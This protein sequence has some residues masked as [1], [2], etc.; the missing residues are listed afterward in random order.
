[1][2]TF[3]REQDFQYFKYVVYF[4]ALISSL[5]GGASMMISSCF[6][7]VCDITNS[8]NLTHRLAILQTFAFTGSFIGYNLAALLMKYFKLTNQF[9]LGFSFLLFLHLCNIFISCIYIKLPKLEA[10]TEEKATIGNL[11]HKKHFLYN[12]QMIY[13]DG[14]LNTK[15]ILFNLCAMASFY[16]LAIQQISLFPYLKRPP[17]SIES[18]IYGYFQAAFFLLK[19]ISLLLIFPKLNKYLRLRFVRAYTAQLTEQNEQNKELNQLLNLDELY[20]KTD[21]IL[22]LV[23]F[24][25]KFAG[26]LALGL[27]P[28]LNYL[29]LVPFMFIFS[30]FTMPTIRS[31]I[32]KQVGANE[33]GKSLGLL[34]FCQNFC[35]FTGS[36]IFKYLFNATRHLDYGISFD[37]VAFI[38]LFSI[39][40]LM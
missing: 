10:A 5:T 20:Q 36:I 23:S 27:I 9:Q 3:Y 15:L 4:C 38:Q 29:P 39:I 30:E 14:K 11:I 24:V 17:F 2:I 33:R 34:S 13:K 26:L 7:Y 37:L 22:C 6:A 32:V 8:K 40:T 1:M 12:L 19:G 16:C 25:S 35:L 31:L 18:S 21:I 28:N